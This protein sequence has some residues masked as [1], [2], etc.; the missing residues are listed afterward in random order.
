MA[1]NIEVGM[2]TVTC[3]KGH[4]YA[5]PHW[6]DARNYRCPMCASQTVSDIELNNGVLQRK[7]AHLE[8]VIRSLRGALKRKK[9]RK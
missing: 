7:Y 6:M 9:A 3:H 2:S 5:V 8:R 1:I 4:F